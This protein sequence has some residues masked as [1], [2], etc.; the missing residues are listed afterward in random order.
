VAAAI[1]RFEGLAGAFDPAAA[2]A[3]AERFGRER[4]RAALRE[5]LARQGVCRP[6]AR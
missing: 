5:Y 6:A 3:S 4:C 2:R 1:E